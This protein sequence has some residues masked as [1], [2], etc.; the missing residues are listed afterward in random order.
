MSFVF[1]AVVDCFRLAFGRR[2]LVAFILRG[3]R[4]M[5]IAKDMLCLESTLELLWLFLLVRSTSSSAFLFLFSSPSGHGPTVIR[6]STVKKGDPLIYFFIL[7]LGSFFL[8]FF[9]ISLFFWG[10]HGPFRTAAQRDHCPPRMFSRLA[11]EL[12]HVSPNPGCQL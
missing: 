1:G 5:K 4:K 3:E 6:S 7:V 9:G 10:V 11:W 12:C 2:L 8:Y